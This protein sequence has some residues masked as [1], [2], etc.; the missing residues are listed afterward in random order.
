MPGV[1]KT[2]LPARPDKA[3]QS[4][5][6]DDRHHMT[7]NRMA[8]RMDQIVSAWIRYASGNVENSA[9]IETHSTF[10]R[11]DRANPPRH[12][13]TLAKEPSNRYVSVIRNL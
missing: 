3:E 4:T 8:S 2:S 10:A 9:L 7:V 12:D 5:I 6:I 11:M 1:R 13:S